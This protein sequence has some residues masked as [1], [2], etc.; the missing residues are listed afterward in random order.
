[1][2]FNDIKFFSYLSF[3]LP[4][5]IISGPFISELIIISI[6]IFFIFK[7]VS[8]KNFVY[9]NNIF[10]K[11]FLSFVFVLVVSSLFSDEKIYSLK[12]SLGYLRYG[13]FS[14]SILYLINNFKNYLKYFLFFFLLT[15][16]G[17]LLDSYIQL[18]LGFNF[19]GQTKFSSYIVTSLFGEEIILGSY[20]L[21]VS[22]LFLAVTMLYKKYN[23]KIDLFYFFIIFIFPMIFFSGQRTPFYL[24]LIFLT[25][26]LFIIGTKKHLALTFVPLILIF[27]IINQDKV[28]YEGGANSYKD[29]MVSDIIYNFKNISNNQKKIINEYGIFKHMFISPGHNELWITSIEIFKRNA[30][31]GS[32]PNT[33]RKKCKDFKPDKN[34]SCSTHP[35]NFSF[36]LLSETGLI[37]FFFYLGLYLILVLE[38]LKSIYQ[39]KCILKRS[40][41][42]QI[43]NINI[44]RL[45]LISSFLINF[46]PI[47]PNGNFF[48]NYLN[49][50]MFMP[51]GFLMYFN[52][53]KKRLK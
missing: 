44:P 33:F 16:A 30:L 7:V 13:I 35:H 22:P 32:G 41:K 51:F 39:T 25:I 18:I 2:K 50:L 34:F 47:T 37:G 29:R 31:L 48:N 43:D 19:L 10:I 38:L 53:L 42:F 17:L 14:L 36:Q 26:T 27:S 5:A 12:Y 6:S 8:E 21:R 9:F 45:L 11:F 1:M 4:A 23:K 46:N 40:Q 28:E 52:N 3:F 49:I 24:S 20:L 15:V